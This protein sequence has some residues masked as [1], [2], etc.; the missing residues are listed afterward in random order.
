MAATRAAGAWMLS[1]REPAVVIVMERHVAVEW[2]I[3]GM[4]IG[5]YRA[6]EC[7]A[8]VFAD[9]AI[10]QHLARTV[11]VDTE[12]DQVMPELPYQ[13]LYLP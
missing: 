1:T 8:E 6:E 5:D 9:E 2:E 11:T 12:V 10:R 4:P 7:V 3:P 13:R